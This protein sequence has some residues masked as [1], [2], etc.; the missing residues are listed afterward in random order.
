V[1]T[2]PESTAKS[3]VRQAADDIRQAFPDWGMN[4]VAD[5][6]GGLWVELTGVPLRAPYVQQDT[7]VVFLLPF[8]L[9]GSDIYP[10]F[11]RPD[12]ARVDGRPVGDGFQ[13]TQLS[14]P[15]EAAARAV[16][17]VSRRTRGSFISQTASQKVVKVLDWVRTR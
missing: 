6:Q 7:F 16:L 2:T 13:A 8:T 10:I 14:W 3:A 1:T 11:V 4:T 12:L 9:P 17:Q 5:G 15:G